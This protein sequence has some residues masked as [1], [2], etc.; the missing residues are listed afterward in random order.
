MQGD[1]AF[2][3]ICKTLHLS[4]AFVFNLDANIA[5]ET[6]FAWKHSSL[7]RL[8]HRGSCTAQ[9]RPWSD[10]LEQEGHISKLWTDSS[11]RC[12]SQALP[13]K[14]FVTLPLPFANRLQ[15][16]EHSTMTPSH[17]AAR[18][19]TLKPNNSREDHLCDLIVRYTN[20]DLSWR[21]SV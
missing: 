5:D 16:C 10:F 14:G 9:L 6:F 1:D 8:V 20:Y 21:S 2:D 12:I 13:S 17:N 18:F 15:Q 19:A 11:N 4:S 3:Q 7:T